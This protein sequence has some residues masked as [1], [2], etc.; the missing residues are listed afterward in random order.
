MNTKPVTIDGSSL[1]V[2]MVHAVAREMRPVRLAPGRVEAMAASRQV[3]QRLIDEGAMIYGITTGM[4][5]MREFLVPKH[6]APEMQMNLLRA[7]ATNVGD[8]FPDEVVRASMLA[9]LNSLCRGHSA[10]QVSNFNVLLDML[11]AGIHP[12]VPCKGSLGA[13]GDL[14][15]LAAIALAATGEG[16][17]SYRGAIVPASQALEEAGIRPM[18]LDFK[19]GL[20]LINGTSVMAGLGALVV[21][22]MEVVGNSADVVAAFSVEALTGRLGP[23]D[24]RVHWQKPHPGQQETAANIMRL[25]RGS[26]MAIS[27]EVLQKSVAARHSTES[28]RKSDVLIMDAYSIRC[29]PHVHGPYKE[30]A[31]WSRRIVERELNSSND[32]PLVLPEY[33]G[34]FHNGHFHGQYVAMVMDAVAV[35]ATTIGLMSDRRIDRYM[36]QNH[37]SGLPP[38]LCNGNPGVRMGM[39]GGQFMTSSVVA[40]NRAKCNPIS[41]QSIPSTED[42]QDFVSMGLVA[43]RRTSEVVHDT[44]YVLAFELMCAAQAADIRGAEKLSPVGRQTY[45]LTREVAPPFDVDV[46]VTPHVEK[47]AENILDGQYA[48][49]L[50]R[51]GRRAYEMVEAFETTASAVHT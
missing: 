34:C 46:S 2:E 39:M 23:F 33:N 5:G 47:I 28:T 19:E 26:Q 27:E 32:D 30:C 25:T 20:A 7:V 21:Y 14:G 17:V 10:I 11:N 1:D 13:S 22:D 15:P 40:E 35:G 43:A 3:L 38:F 24:E 37:S 4:G 51:A 12:R 36:D 29:V 45:E 48:A 6:V 18:R 49:I 41:V 42:F 16:M 50:S 9:R 8:C 31:Q 44:A